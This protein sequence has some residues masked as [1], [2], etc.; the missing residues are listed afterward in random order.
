MAWAGPEWAGMGRDAGRRTCLAMR[1]AAAFAMAAWSW[2]PAASS[3]SSA[4]EVCTTPLPWSPSC[5]RSRRR[6]FRLRLTD[7]REMGTD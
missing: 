7:Y 6:R 2:Q 3:A 4:H 5:W 1:K